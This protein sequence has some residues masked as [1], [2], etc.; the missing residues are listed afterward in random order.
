MKTC[1]KTKKYDFY[2]LAKKILSY[3]DLNELL[4]LLGKEIEKINPVSG[5]SIS[6]LDENQKNLV[7]QKIS[8]PPDFKN[9][10]KA[11]Y[12]YSMPIDSTDILAKVL[13]EKQTLYTNL[14]HLDK[15]GETVRSR[16]MLWKIKEAYTL[17]ISDGSRILGSLLIYVNDEVQGS[18]NPN[19][20]SLLEEKLTLFAPQLA[21]SLFYSRLKEKEMILKT[22]A[23]KNKKVLAIAYKINNLTSEKLI[24]TQIIKELL[25]LFDFDFGGFFLYKNGV[26][27]VIDYFGLKSEYNQKFQSMKN[28]PLNRPFQ[29]TVNESAVSICFLQNVH[30]YLNDYQQ[31]KHLPVLPRDKEFIDFLGYDIRTHFLMPVRKDGI[32]IG[33]ITL[34]SLEKPLNLPGEDIQTISEICSF[35]SSAID[36]SRLYSLIDHQKEEIRKTKNFVES[37]VE[38]APIAIYT[39]D[40]TG[41][42]T[43]ENPMM[44]KLLEDF[45]GKAVG[46]NVFELESIR[47]AG[48]YDSFHEALTHGKH[49]DFMNL[50]FLSSLTG[51]KLVLNVSISPIYQNEEISG[52]I[53]MYY[54]NTEKAAAEEEI[55]KLSHLTILINSTLDI[56]KIFD[57]VFI[58][59][60]NEFHFEGLIFYLPDEKEENLFPDKIL[61]QNL[62]Q[63][64]VDEINHIK[65]PLTEEGRI[66]YAFKNNK[67]LYFNQHNIKQIYKSSYDKMMVEKYSLM[68]DVVLPIEIYN[69]VIGIIELVNFSDFLELSQENLEKI[70]GFI[71]HITSAIYNSRLYQKMKENNLELEKAKNEIQA[72]NEI[73]KQ[74]NMKLSLP[75]VL[76]K[77][78][79]YLI[80]NYGFEGIRISLV[81]PDKT[82]YQIH[83]AKI[84]VDMPRE[85]KDFQESETGKIYPLDERGG[86]VTE[87]ILSNQISFFTD[88]C[89]RE[90]EN[91]VSREIVEKLQMKSVLNM[92]IHIE[93]EV[94]GAF[95]LSTHTRFIYLNQE[96]IASIKRFVEQ[97][98]V[99]LRNAKL[100]DEIEKT[101]NALLE[102]DRVISEDLMMA[103]RIQNNVIS[104]SYKTIGELDF[105]VHYQP[106]FEVGGDIYDIFQLK[107]GVIRIFIADATG[108]GVQAALTTMIIKT[109]YEKVKIFELSVN[110]I[111]KTL[112]RAFL[113][114]YANLTVFFSCILI[115]I[116]LNQMKLYYSSAGHPVQYLIRGEELVELKAGGKLIGLFDSFEYEK[117]TMDIQKEDKIFLFTDG[118]FEEFNDQEEELGIDELKRIIEKASILPLNEMGKEVLKDV[119][120]YIGKMDL[121]DDISVLGVRIK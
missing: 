93:D 63:N 8:M 73:A 71:S 21:H 80:E 106:Q 95:T 56:E 77:I 55:Q 103:K 33:V 113:N 30:F 90:I 5:Y 20:I 46:S 49:F 64:F 27:E 114:Q 82:H 50:K 88:I 120:N 2:H 35:I 69:Q 51:K 94:I 65:I 76:E 81:Q 16:F 72:M 74:I 47:K 79:N 107:E 75:I 22:A 118:L 37:I 57:M 3:I 83:I 31:L 66:P 121:N 100:Y 54:D 99:V 19:D 18:F 11:Y 108:H 23:E 29:I 1:K 86:R 112:N 12:R 84:F 4:D 24:Y 97:I 38:Y 15:V 101:K 96:D 43:S 92:P 34:T 53:C 25:Q 52:A 104:D 60:N 26:L 78:Q 115:D 117:V 91:K 41:V 58:Y 42:I 67:T 87:C 17:P 28:L 14:N 98:S 68:T 61:V 13:K 110:H 85:I 7:I 45:E 59:I 40:K 105:F 6:M 119:E 9:I 62:S 44:K 109:E 36:N 102:K 48:I 70:R 39:I 10:E 111:L 89:P 116:D 32:P